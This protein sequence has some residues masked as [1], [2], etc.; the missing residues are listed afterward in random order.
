[1]RVSFD[2]YI[3]SVIITSTLPYINLKDVEMA[4]ANIKLRHR[5]D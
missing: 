1:M 2:W 4:K 5:D 3:H